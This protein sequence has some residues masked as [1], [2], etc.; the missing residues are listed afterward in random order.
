LR[1]DRGIMEAKGNR[2]S[3]SINTTPKAKLKGKEYHRLILL[4]NHST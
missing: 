1:K 2:F 3:S 4:H